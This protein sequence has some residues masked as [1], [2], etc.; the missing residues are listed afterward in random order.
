[1]KITTEDNTIITSDFLKYDKKIGLLQLEKNVTAKDKQ[2][3][4][5]KQIKQNMM[6]L[7]KFLKVTGIR[8]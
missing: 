8:Q 1:M 7:I 3:N 2:N 4:I 6:K 5:I